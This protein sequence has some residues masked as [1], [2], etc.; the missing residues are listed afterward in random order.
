[1]SLTP[2][3][4]CTL[5]PPPFAARPA[6]AAPG[7]TSPLLFRVPAPTHLRPAHARRPAPGPK[8]ALTRPVILRKPQAPRC[9]TLCAHAHAHACGLRA[10]STRTTHRRAGAPACCAAAAARATGR[11]PSLHC[12][13]PG[14]PP[15]GRASWAALRPLDCIVCHPCPLSCSALLS[16]A[17][18]PPWGFCADPPQSA[19]CRP[20]A[21]GC[22]GA[23]VR[24]KSVRERAT[25][26]SLL[27]IS[28]QAAAPSALSAPCRRPRC[29]RRLGAAGPRP[30]RLRHAPTV[31]CL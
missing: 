2:R 22:R 7:R 20:Q 4:C 14:L 10:H 17:L 12:Q 26:H 9:A 5:N 23:S 25:P 29:R 28:P 13:P 30:A 11:R 19:I 31:L 16:L 8:V 21:T 1:M 24:E 6:A 18:A 27:T 3:A 15:L